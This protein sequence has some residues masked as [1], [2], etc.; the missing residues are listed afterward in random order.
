MTTGRLAI[1]PGATS[2]VTLFTCHANVLVA[3]PMRARLPREL[4]ILKTESFNKTASYV[5]L[6]TSTVKF[7]LKKML[8]MEEKE[9]AKVEEGEAWTWRLRKEISESTA[10]NAAIARFQMC[11]VESN[12][13][14]EEKEEDDDDEALLTRLELKS[15]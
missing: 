4:V 6:V 3:S 11:P 1:S 14:E 13:D 2:I 15:S 5:D 12:S 7:V 9:V 8:L 10:S